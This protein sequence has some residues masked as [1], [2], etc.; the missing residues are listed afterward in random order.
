MVR[1]TNNHRVRNGMELIEKNTNPRRYSQMINYVRVQKKDLCTRTKRVTN[2]NGVKRRR[3]T[4]V[5]GNYVN[6]VK[7]F[8]YINTDGILLKYQNEKNLR[9]GGSSYNIGGFV[10][11]REEIDYIYIDVICAQTGYGSEL[12]NE[13]VRIARN[14]NKLFLT[15]SSVPEAIPFYRRQNFNFAL[16]GMPV[17][18]RIRT[19]N[20]FARNRIGNFMANRITFMQML[21]NLNNVG[22]VQNG[23]VTMTRG[24]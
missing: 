11:Y 4:G 7:R 6:N 1:N 8:N 2:S 13:M 12:I 9:N 3:V 10:I 23:L 19:N 15:L 20:R 22:L 16:P 17:N 24:V 18:N 21:A 14:K 5:Q